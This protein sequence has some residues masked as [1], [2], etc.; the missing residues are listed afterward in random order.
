M[1]H[2]VSRRWGQSIERLLMRPL[3]GGL[4]SL[5]ALGATACSAGGGTSSTPVGSVREAVTSTGSTCNYAVST[6]VQRVGKK[7]FRGQVNVTNVGGAT[8]TD[9][10]VL[11][12]A[13]SDA[14]VKVGHGTFEPSDYGYL[15]S[16]KPKLSKKGLSQGETYS[17]EVKFDGPYVPMTAN[18]LSNNGVT[19]DQTAPTI[20]LAAT[21]DFYTSNGTL[22]LTAQASDDV[23]VGKVV[24]TQDGT[25][26]AT[27]TQAPYSV[28]VPVTNAL[29]GRHVYAAT[30][31]DLSNNQASE[32]QTVLVAIGDKFFGT[33][34]T[35]AEDYTNLLAHF[36]QVTPGNA[37]KWGSV[38]AVQG[39]MNWTDLD[40]AYNFAK[41]NHIPFKMHT[42][43]WGSQQPAW[44]DSLS[45]ADQLTAIDNWMAAVA[46]RYPA[47]D[48]ID[49]VN[50]PLHTP[51]S[52]AAALGGA[53]AT[54]W[55]W[56]I[57]AFEMARDHFPNA[58]LLVN[59]YSILPLA[60]FT[61]QYLTIVNLLNDRGLIDGIAEQ[62]HFYERSPDPSVLA[63]NLASLAATGLPLYISELD[64]AL[65]DDAQQAQRMSQIFPIFWSNPSVVGVTHWGY[66]QGNMWQPDAYLI[67]TDGSLRP[68]LTWLECYKAGGTNCPVPT[69]VPQPHTGDATGI[70][71]PA[72][73]Y[74]DANGL[75]A[76]GNVVAY[77]NDGSWLAYD[78]VAFQN[79]WNNLSV[80]YA[81]GSTS[82]INLTVSLGSLSSAPVATVPLAPTGSWS[83]NQTVTIPWAS[84][85]TTQDVYVR[86]NGGG[87]NLQTFQFAPT[88]T[89][90]NIVQN[91]TFESGASGWFTFNGGTL[92]ATTARAHSGAQSLFVTNRA[93]NAPAATDLTSVVTPGTSYP[94]SLWAS[95]NSPDGSSQAINVTEAASCQ[96]SD[97]T[98]STT[99]TW[100][101]GP[102]T[103]P[104]G[105]TWTQ[106]T[107]TVAVPNCALTQLLFWVEGGAGADLYVDDVQ[108]NATSTGPVNLIPDGTFES[109]QGAWGGWGEASVAVT[110][111]AAHSGTQSLKGTTMSNGALSRD[112]S[113]LVT[114]GKRYTATA[115][116]SVGNLAAGSG[117]VNWQTVQNCN[118]DASD[119]YPW[120]AGATANN[121]AWV[122]VTGTV[123]LTTCTTINKLL[124]FAGAASGDL[125][126]D[127]VSLTALP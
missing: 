101:G 76:L 126:L 17:F 91:G 56:V 1:H 98:V 125:Y 41:A 121:G 114:P 85:G 28:S 31:Y 23:G 106:F 5:F 69:Y 34:V 49:V 55:D 53:G 92:S 72:V 97:G 81:L 109:G 89:T 84:V 86:F 108:V 104:S 61:Q 93:S 11:V 111:T 2:S 29:N 120:L 67:R 102:L 18:I 24:F 33:A 42:L 12:S 3:S 112:I 54:G 122:Q 27:F 44:I 37:G 70:T 95:I 40:T 26:I 65:S 115:W 60:S 47:I 73:D 123:D 6:D 113:G 10:S 13:G 118:S 117:S 38:E 35:E 16:P 103:L 62:G 32:E 75:L 80:T 90:T 63:T 83:T 19:C 22:T 99:Y 77:A 127:D 119:S 68:S 50:E 96:A 14:L 48:L 51:P 9:F 66:L 57:T 110:N 116:V 64:L 88:T 7:R 78:Q 74:D 100:V 39:Q 45:P 105:N 124:L 52:Y 79:T 71:L 25:P 107:G 8:S 87:A 43:V 20:S 15:L 36:D 30:A 94:F 4:V 46:A 21:G 82:P 58:Q 59:D